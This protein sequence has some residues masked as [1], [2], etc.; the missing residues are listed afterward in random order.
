MLAA[1]HLDNPHFYLTYARIELN[2]HSYLT[3]A[4]LK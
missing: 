1:L 3:Y 4:K 2:P